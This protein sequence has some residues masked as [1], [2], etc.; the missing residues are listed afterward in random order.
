MWKYLIKTTACLSLFGLAL[1]SQA[2]ADKRK[3]TI[4]SYDSFVSEWGPGPQIEAAFEANC[5]CDL[6]FVGLDS[7]I[8]ILGRAQMEASAPKADILLGLDTNL[9][10]RA[11]ATGLL[12]P[13]GTTLSHDNLPVDFASDIFMPVDWGYFAFVYDKNRLASPPMSFEALVNSDLTI[14][15]Q[16]PRTSTPGLGLLMWVK[17]VY[18]NEAAD[19]WQQLQPR[20]LTVTKSWWDA[21]S[22]FLEGEADMVLSYTTSPAYHAIAEGKDNYAAASFTDGHY[23]QVEVAAMLKDA[24][25]PDL[26]KSFMQFIQTAEFQAIIPTTNWMYP[27][28][29]S[30]IP[31]GFKGLVSPAKSHLFSA[32]AAEEGRQ[33]FVDEW[34]KASQ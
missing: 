9:M 20:I 14:A 32:K 2:L 30:A 16:D 28:L 22:L 8:G 6:V 11:E 26:A 3:L 29:K 33:L 1:S 21:Y 12:A 15:I 7:S 10:T 24:P 13:H 4:Y 25:Q 5:E 27:T 19:Y 34:L 17:S 31:D 18:G 23:M